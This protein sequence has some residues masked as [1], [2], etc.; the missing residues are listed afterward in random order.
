MYCALLRKVL[1]P[2]EF[3]VDE[4]GSLYFQEEFR[5]VVKMF[6]EKKICFINFDVTATQGFVI[7]FLTRPP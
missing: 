3:I 6:H 1:S 7:P 2:N 4:S 5:T